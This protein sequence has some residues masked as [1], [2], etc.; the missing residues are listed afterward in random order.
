[1]WVAMFIYTH[2]RQYTHKDAHKRPQDTK[3][4]EG[5]CTLKYTHTHA[6]AHIHTYKDPKTCTPGRMLA[7]PGWEMHPATIQPAP[8]LSPLR[9]EGPPPPSLWSLAPQ[10]APARCAT[11]CPALS[12]INCRASLLADQPS[13][14]SA[15][16]AITQ[17]PPLACVCRVSLPGRI[18]QTHGALSGSAWPFPQGILRPPVV[19]PQPRP[20]GDPLPSAQRSGGHSSMTAGHSGSGGS[21]ACVFEHV[22]V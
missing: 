12:H 17:L 20:R 13:R 1:M 10:P 7:K 15:A 6:H 9:R 5:R 11:I 21:Q 8:A 19:C 16:S 22:C 3:F 4:Y 2:T 14:P 18:V